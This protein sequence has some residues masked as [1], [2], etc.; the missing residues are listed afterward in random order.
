MADRHIDR[1][2]SSKPPKERK[3]NIYN[4]SINIRNHEQ[5]KL[6]EDED[7][8]TTI[9]SVI[10]KIMKKSRRLERNQLKQMVTDELSDKFD[11]N[12]GDYKNILEQMMRS[13]FIDVDPNDSRFILY[14]P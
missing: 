13:E 2:F 3:I 6:K 1:K 14:I 11:L 7:H 4:G 12:D 5:Q 9:Q 10:G 8:T